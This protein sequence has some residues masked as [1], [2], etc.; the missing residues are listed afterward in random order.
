MREVNKL[1][2]SDVSTLGDGKHADG[3]GLYLHVKSDARSWVFRYK[4]NGKQVYVGLGSA[5]AVSLARARKLSQE[6]RGKLA[7]GE[8]VISPK[9]AA[10]EKEKQEVQEAQT[11]ELIDRI[12]DGS[13]DKL[14]AAGVSFLSNKAFSSAYVC[15]DRIPAKDFKLLYN[16]ALCCFMVE[17]YDECHRL[18]CEAERL[19]PMNAGHSTERLPEAFLRYLH[20]EESPFCPI[21]Q[22]TPEP[23]AY[24][25]HTHGSC[26]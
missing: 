3:Q 18:L 17:W 22:G 1:K 7:T 19:V 24:S 26:G 8:V 11:N 16:K 25:W 5:Y 20:D 21:S 2:A 23:L 9:K 10:L 13:A 15:F 12:Y 6:L 4:R 14:F